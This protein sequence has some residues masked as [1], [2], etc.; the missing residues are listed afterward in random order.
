MAGTIGRQRLHHSRVAVVALYVFV[1]AA[2]AF[3]HHDFACRQD[4][5]THCIAC[6]VSQDAQR[7]ETHGGPLDT[8]QPL[9][10]RVEPRTHA[11]IDIPSLTFLSDRAPPADIS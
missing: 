5:R 1:V 8:L 11:S 7:A 6:S 9:A 3:F 10:G 4:S 2:S